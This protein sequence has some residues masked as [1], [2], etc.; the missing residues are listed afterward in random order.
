[1]GTILIV[2][3]DRFT[4]LAVE[5]YLRSF[6]HNVLTAEDGR[7]ALE[8]VK[9]HEPDLILLDLMM[10]VMDG[11]TFLQKLRKELG[12]QDLPVIALTALAQKD[13]VV[14]ILRFGALDYITKPFN[15]TSL[16]IKV[17]KI[18]DKLEPEEQETGEGETKEQSSEAK[19]NAEQPEA[20]VSEP[21]TQ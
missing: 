19:D 13:K 14:K 5:K 18:M 9:E 4:R 8:L 15:P 16:M 3:D 21:A 10:P 17:R 20:E 1:M 7:E 12:K 11:E 6:G 2:D